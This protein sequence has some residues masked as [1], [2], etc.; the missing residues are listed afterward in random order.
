VEG[1]PHRQ[2]EVAFHLVGAPR[3]ALRLVE[4][5]RRLA[6]AQVV[7]T[8]ALRPSLGLQQLTVQLPDGLLLQ[9][10]K[11]LHVVEHQPVHLPADEPTAAEVDVQGVH[12]LRQHH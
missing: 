6:A 12:H 11:A 8:V 9:E 3:P 1:D 7:L 2:V 10:G 4:G 5:H